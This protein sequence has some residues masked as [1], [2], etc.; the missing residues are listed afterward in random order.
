MIK[1]LIYPLAGIAVVVIFVFIIAVVLTTISDARKARALHHAKW[2]PFVDVKGDGKAEIGVHQVARWGRHSKVLHADKRTELI[3]VDD[4]IAR[5]NAYSE[6]ATRAENYNQL[7]ATTERI[8][9]W[10]DT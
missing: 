6:A 9:T 7:D 10:D 4:F 8:R 1:G 5:I 3:D 2:E